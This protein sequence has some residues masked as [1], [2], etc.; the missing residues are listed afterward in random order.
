MHVI[1]EN[2]R[3]STRGACDIIDITSEL[4]RIISKHNIKNGNATVFVSGSTA[5]VTTIEYEP[6]LKKDLSD[7]FEHIA[8][9]NERYHHDATWN[10]GN[11]HAHIRASLLGPSLVLPFSDGEL[12]VGTW[13]QVVVV[14]FDNRPR[15]R[16]IVVQLIGE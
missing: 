7:A 6:G 2:V 12:M 1:T 3:V 8:P 16:D 11:G 10:D 14:D 5:G 9:Q 4:S 15:T 13:Q